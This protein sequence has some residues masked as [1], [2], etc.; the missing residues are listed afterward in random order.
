MIEIIEIDGAEATD[1]R[2]AE[3]AR[4]QSEATVELNG[5]APVP[6]EAERI[7]RYR[8]PSARIRYWLALVDDE[9]AGFAY[10]AGHAPT[11]VTA[12]VGVIPRFR[13]SGVGTALF[14]RVQEAARERGLSS[15]V[16]HH[17]TEAG[18]AF[19]RSLG[20]QD[21]QLDV[22]SIL[23]LRDVELPEPTPPPGVELRTW[24]GACPDELV[25]SFVVARSAIGDAPVAGEL[26][27]PAWTVDRQRVE[28]KSIEGRGLELLTTAALD[29]GEVVA[30]TTIRIQ[31]GA[32][33]VT[34]DT[35]T[36]PSHRG[37]GLATAVKIESLRKLRERR[38]DVELVGTMNAA[39]NPAMLAVNRKLGFEPTVFLT[40]AVVTL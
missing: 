39:R 5:G 15:F 20:A 10:V 38:P 11:F 2:L 6:T 31:P 1:A 13:R 40:C 25:E 21:D 22:K 3:L 32:F 29:G 23:R 34:D 16:G 12:D 30:L 18:A 27:L 7:A 4:V 9:P 17:G 35:A 19:A 36:L 37:Q 8:N 14:E 24:G 33:A 28:E 26:M